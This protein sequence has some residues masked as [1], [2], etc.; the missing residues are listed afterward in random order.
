MDMVD[1]EVDKIDNAIIGVKTSIIVW[2]MMGMTFLKILITRIT[3]TI[4]NNWG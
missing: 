3:E 4:D 2:N 1:I